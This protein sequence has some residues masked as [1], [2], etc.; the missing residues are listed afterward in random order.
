[1]KTSRAIGLTQSILSSVLIKAIVVTLFTSCLFISNLVAASKHK[2]NDV[3]KDK[4]HQASCEN[5]QGRWL[6]ELGST[7]IISKLKKDGSVAGQFISPPENGAEQFQ[8]VGWFNNTR[9]VTD[10]HFMP[11]LT[12][13]INWGEYGS[14]SAWS[15]GCTVKNGVPTLVM[16]MNLSL[17]NA[18]YEWDHIITGSDRFTPL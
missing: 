1:M 11:A 6:N 16:I 14:V 13:S 2:N 17:V 9:A 7:L 8:V 4:T 3:D 12:F 18:Q 15:G 5:M 10:L